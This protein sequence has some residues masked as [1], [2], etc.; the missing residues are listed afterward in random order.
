ME[1]AP[2]EITFQVREDPDGGYYAQAIGF[3]IFTQGDDWDD[4][5]YM[6]KDAVLCHFDEGK[7][8]AEVRIE[9][10]KEAEVISV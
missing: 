5:K 3:S 8:P 1:R 9:L 10:V 4:L 7:G 2:R 6:I